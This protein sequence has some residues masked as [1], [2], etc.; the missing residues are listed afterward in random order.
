MEEEL[1][2]P[3]LMLDETEADGH[4]EPIMDYVISWCIRRAD[5]RCKNEKPILYSY[6]RQILAKLL[7]I[8]LTDDVEFHDVKVWK[9]WMRIDLSVEL[10]VENAGERTK[11]AILIENKYYTGLR[12]ITNEKRE[13]KNQLEVYKEIFKAHYEK[14]K[15]EGRYWEQH[16]A[17]ITCI[18]RDNDNFS[19]YNAADD[20]KFKKFYLKELLDEANNNNPILTE[21]DIFN[22]FWFKWLSD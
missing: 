7:E 15:S 10:E 11:H 8:A 3:Q 4:A 16:Y 6:C 12:E 19:I 9:Q 20:L 18:K 21:S 2:K 5:V 17:L 1:Y 14:E 22:E 13:R